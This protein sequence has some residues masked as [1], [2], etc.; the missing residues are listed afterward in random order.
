MPTENPHSLLLSYAM[1]RQ[2]FSGDSNVLGKSVHIG[3]V[4]YV[5]VG[6]MPPQ[7][8]Y[9]MHDDRPQ[10]WVPVDRSTQAASDP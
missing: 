8:E 2:S 5:V 10:I 3:G 1:W 6:V 4:P 9:P 7:F